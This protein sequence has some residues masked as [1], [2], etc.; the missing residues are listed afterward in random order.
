MA[1][2]S[3]TANDLDRAP[4]AFRRIAPPRGLTRA[5]VDRIAGDIRAG[6]LRRTWR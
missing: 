4:A 5:V 6:R 1:Q 3:I 2:V